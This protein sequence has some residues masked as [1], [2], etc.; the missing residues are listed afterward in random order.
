M[1]SIAFCM[2]LTFWF[3]Q[4]AAAD[5]GVLV[6]NI[7]KDLETSYKTIYNTLEKNRFFIVFEPNIQGNLSSFAERWG[8]NYNRNKLEG[9]RAMVFCNI[10]YTNEIS[11][12]DPDMLAMCPL[13]M[14]L[15]QQAGSTRVLFIRPTVVAADSKALA[16]A[17]ELEQDISK[18]MD[19]AVNE[20]R[21]CPEAC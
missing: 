20:L 1:R 2:V 10:W 7:D 9:I 19:E 4:L 15:I 16:I 13:H 21:G 5:S 17:K 3:G 11:N 18:A 12:A 14:T 8:D 6:W